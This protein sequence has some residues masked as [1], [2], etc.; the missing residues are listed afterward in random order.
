[1]LVIIVRHAEAAPKSGGTLDEDRKLTEYGKIALRNNLMLAKEIAGPSVNLI[2]SSPILRARES[3][4]IAGEIFGLTSFE[5]D[6]SLEPNSSPY[7]VY[8]R[9]AQSPQLG[10]ILLV[11]HQPLVSQLLVGLL[12]WDERRF[13]F[14]AGAVAVVELKEV[15]TA[16]EGVLLSLIPARK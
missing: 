16:P 9:L 7:E 13:A 6:A 10:K 11:T 1:L 12:G 8:R 5:T 14:S 4:A 2:L 15:T 3:A